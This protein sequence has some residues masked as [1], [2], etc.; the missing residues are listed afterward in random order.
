MGCLVSSDF[1]SLLEGSNSCDNHASLRHVF[2]SRT[3]MDRR[4]GLFHWGVRHA[5]LL[6]LNRDIRR[7]IHDENSLHKAANSISTSTLSTFFFLYLTNS[8]LGSAFSLH[9]TDTTRWNWSKKHDCF[10]G[11]LISRSMNWATDSN[12]LS[13]Q[14]FKYF[15]YY[16][17]YYYSIPVS[18]IYYEHWLINL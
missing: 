7:I 15:K 17:P 3:Y 5:G 13:I 18:L 12:T 9:S 8:H 10:D 16:Y 6:R 11:Y 2:S 1:G 4:D 14:R